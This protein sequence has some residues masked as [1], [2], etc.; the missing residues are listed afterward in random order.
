VAAKII[1]NVDTTAAMHSIKSLSKR[2]LTIHVED[3]LLG[4]RW[5]HVAIA[6]LAGVHLELGEKQRGQQ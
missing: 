1:Q 6:R 2:T 3:N 5:N 4:Q